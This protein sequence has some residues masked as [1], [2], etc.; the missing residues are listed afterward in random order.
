MSFNNLNP[1]SIANRRVSLFL[2]DDLVGDSTKIEV[3]AP[4]KS[5]LSMLP[6]T[7]S[8]ASVAPLKPPVDNT[9]KI[10][11]NISLTFETTEP[12][13]RD[14]LL[15]EV[16][17]TIVKELKINADRIHAVDTKLVSKYMVFEK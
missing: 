2:G 16:L 1:A 10:L 12:A 17:E 13:E 7:N 4:F 6:K 3:A 5:S 9:H 14:A 8:T 15:K 11:D